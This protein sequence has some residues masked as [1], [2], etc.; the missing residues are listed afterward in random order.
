M[1]TTLPY[2]SWPSPLTADLLAT[3]GTRLGSPR[4]VGRE[5]WWTE[6]IATEGGRQAIVRTAGPVA[7]PPAGG[8]EGPPAPSVPADRVTVLPAP[9]NARSRVHEYGGSSWGVV[10]APVPDGQGPLVVFVNFADQR[11][12]A[13]REGEQPR[14]L[15]PVG[16]EVESAHGPS[17]RWADPTVITLADGS[18]EV[19]W[20]CEDHAG[21]VGRT[22]GAD[23]PSPDGGAPRPDA[24]GAPH[25]ERSIVAVPLDGSAAEDPAALRRITPAYRFVAHPRLSPDGTHLAWIS[26]E[27][28]QMPWDGTE[29]QDRKSTRLNSSHELKSRMPSSA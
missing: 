15:T 2:G 1:V 29:L 14:P 21:L 22:A 16:P 12:H 9:F 10:P 27:H 28:P 5:V 23:G 17:L 25:I 26:W 4:L 24:D 6:G 3:G 19:W 18:T 7:L 8:A 11:V 13:L 20:V